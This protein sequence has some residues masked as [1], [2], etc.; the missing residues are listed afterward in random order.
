MKCLLSPCGRFTQNY[1]SLEFFWL[2]FFV[3]SLVAKGDLPSQ[4]FMYL[5][6]LSSVAF[7]RL[8][9]RALSERCTVPAGITPFDLTRPRIQ[10][11]FENAINSLWKTRKKIDPIA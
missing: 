1:S 10:S 7:V 3:F 9:V 8:Y 4:L 5:S 11:S 2:F 6:R